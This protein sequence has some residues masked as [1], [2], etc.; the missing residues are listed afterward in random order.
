MKNQRSK[1]VL[2]TKGQRCENALGIIARKFTSLIQKAPN[3]TFDINDACQILDIHKRHIYDVTSVLDGLGL[4]KK[5]DKNLI[6][7]IGGTY[8][9]YAP[10]DSETYNIKEL[11]FEQ[12][13][14]ETS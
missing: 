7:W 13:I 2:K 9:Q 4:I 14:K 10:L 1:G 12:F 8:R 6:T 11:H 3:K 5:F